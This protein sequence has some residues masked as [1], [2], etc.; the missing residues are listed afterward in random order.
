M[1]VK[2]QT[3]V[4]LL[5]SYPD[6]VVA[7]MLGV[8]LCTLRRWMESDDFSDALR[9]REREQRATLARLA[10]QAAVNAASSLCQVAS[11]TN[12]PD[13]KVLIEVLKLSGAFDEEVVDP[14]AEL[15][16]LVKRARAEV[17]AN[18]PSGRRE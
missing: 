13:A 15:A 5:M 6:T 7:E 16:E 12:K 18:G 9:R 14:E 1:K 4:E 17:A 2:H 8:Q 3:A 10:R 11:D